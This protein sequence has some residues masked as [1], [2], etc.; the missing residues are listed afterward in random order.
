M[1]FIGNVPAEA[2]SPVAKDTFSG[3]DS[4]TDF[5][6][7]I[8]AT[9]NGVEVLVE[10]VQQEPTTAYTISGTTLSFTAPPVTG[11]DNIYVIHRGPAVQTVVPPGDSI[12]TAMIQDDA[13]TAA[14]IAVTGN[15]TSG[16]ALTS[17]GDGTMSWATISSDKI[18][19]GNSSV[20]VVDTGTG[21]VAVTTDGSEIARFDASGNL[22]VGQ[23][24][25]AIES[26][27]I[28]SAK[29]IE[30]TRT[31]NVDNG[32]LGQISWVNNTNAGA[33]SGTSFVKDV[34]C[35]RGAMEGTGNN[36]GG[37]IV[38]EVKKDAGSRYE[39]VRFNSAGAIIWGSTSATRD[40]CEF[41]NYGNASL[42]VR[43]YA[44]T[45]NC[46]I[47]RDDTT[48]SGSVSVNGSSCSYN[49][50]SDYRLKEDWVP[51]SDSIARVKA[52]NPVNF[53]WKADGTRVD[54]F[55]AHEAQDIV[56]EAVT[57][58]KDEVEAIGNVTDAEGVIVKEGVTE[59]SELPEDQT[60][61]K[62]GDRPV[63][64]GID[65]SKLV[66]LLTAALQEAIAKIETLET[67]VTDLQTRVTALE[68][69]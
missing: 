4:T 21:H 55:L 64:Q 57:G 17:D 50:S 60:W 23:T 28:V 16:Q 69:N 58:T 3:D 38:F 9:T 43:R 51:M 8:P 13:V 29:D 54:G 40:T 7:S 12:T 47:F 44:D 19:E 65:Q 59:P 39:S 5:T 25:A 22:L 45:G 35:I 42:D 61:T 31:L 41:R 52:L 14:K 20:E 62:T 53:A 56:P 24:T 46:M 34:T 37:Y 18:E 15:G 36:S 68:A 27:S 33:A 30:I 66:P 1:S 67:T 63:M 49:T 26:G 48:V 11:T 10:N 32:D 2:Y 6:L